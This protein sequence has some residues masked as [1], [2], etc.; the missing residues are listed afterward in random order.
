[1]AYAD[2]RD[3]LFPRFQTQTG[4]KRSLGSVVRGLNEITDVNS[5]D[6]LDRDGKRRTVKEYL[7]P[8]PGAAVMEFEE[9]KRKRA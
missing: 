1:V 8:D 7:V 2:L 6:D 3:H 5:R 4:C 9:E